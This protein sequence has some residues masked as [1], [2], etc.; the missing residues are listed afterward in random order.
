[1][2][3]LSCPALWR[4]LAAYVRAG[5]PVCFLP[6]VSRIALVKP[7]KARAIEEMLLNMARSGRLGDKVSE[8]MLIQVRLSSQR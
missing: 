8:D 7:D 5:R 4:P 3:F 1:M 2:P 6:A